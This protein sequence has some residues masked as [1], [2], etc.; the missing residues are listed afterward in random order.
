MRRLTDPMIIAIRTTAATP[1]QTDSTAGCSLALDLLLD[2]SHNS[3]FD[4][5]MS[6]HTGSAASLQPI[7][8]FLVAFGACLRTAASVPA[9]LATASCLVQQPPG[10]AL[11]GNRPRKEASIH[12]L[13]HC[14]GHPD[15]ARPYD[16]AG[17]FLLPVPLGHWDLFRDY[18]CGTLSDGSGHEVVD[19]G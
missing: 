3:T 19:I 7:G 18:R 1:T 4:A 16:L 13:H 15:V 9:A 8:G 6:C 10:S 11:G 17:P 14:G 12:R 5:P 2:L